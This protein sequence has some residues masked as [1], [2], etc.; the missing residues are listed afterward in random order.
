MVTTEVS[1]RTGNLQPRSLV[2][3]LVTT[4][5]ATAATPVETLAAAFP[6]GHD[7][8]TREDYGRDLRSWFEWCRAHDVDPLY[9]QRAHVDAYARTLAEVPDANRNTRSRATVAR[10]LS[11]LSGFYKYAVAKDV[12]TRNPVAAV[13][14]PRVGTDKV[15]TGVDKDELSA[16]FRIAEADSPRSLALVLLLGLNGLRIS[17]ALSA[18]VDDLGTERGHHVLVVK[19]KGGNTATVPIAPRTAGAVDE[20]VVTAGM[21]RSSPPARASGGTTQRPGE[22]CDAWRWWRSRPRRRPCIHTISDTP[23]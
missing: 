18:D 22:C 17:E 5:L 8:A 14:R 11:T 13:K 12:I 2:P 9:A 7:E 10:H 19:R 3:T 21:A 23:S 20:Y 16:L 4:E 15:S 1:L 6:L